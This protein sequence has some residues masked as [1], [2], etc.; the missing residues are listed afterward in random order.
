M[1]AAR[2]KKMRQF[3][4]SQKANRAYHWN[5]VANATSAN[6][7]LLVTK[8]YFQTA[9]YSAIAFDA[10]TGTLLLPAQYPH[11]TQTEP[12]GSITLPPHRHGISARQKLV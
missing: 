10:Y 4:E 2:N 8:S 1:T 11:I 7:K 3:N 12:G 6:P 9:E 5:Y